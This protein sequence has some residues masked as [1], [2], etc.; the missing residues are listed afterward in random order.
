MDNLIV[1]PGSML[2]SGVRTPAIPGTPVGEKSGAVAPS[3]GRTSPAVTR[4]LRRNQAALVSAS[5]K[6]KYPRPGAFTPKVGRGP[7]TFLQKVLG[8]HLP[9]SWL[10]AGPKG[11]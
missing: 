4:D 2:M 3:A 8:G 11:R 9:M 5:E 1:S 10:T 7:S 6:P